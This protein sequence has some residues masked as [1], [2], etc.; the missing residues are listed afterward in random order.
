MIMQD[1]WGIGIYNGK[2]RAELNPYH[3]RRGDWVI[4]P[5]GNLGRLNQP[6]FKWGYLEGCDRPYSLQELRPVALV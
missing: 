5:D 3:L 2:S 1:Y 6:G 4:A